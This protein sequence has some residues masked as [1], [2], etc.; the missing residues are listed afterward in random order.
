MWHGFFLVI[1]KVEQGVNMAASIWKGSISF[2]LINIPVILRKAEE[3]KSLS[4]NLLDERDL[5]PIKYKKVNAK[6]GH[7]VP[8]PKIVKGHKYSEEQYVVVTKED[9]KAANPKATQTIDIQ[10][11]ISFDEIDLMYFEKPY[12]LIPQ[13]SG[14]KGYYLLLE[15]LKKTNKVAVATVVI[16]SKMHLTCIMP[17]EN[18]LILEILRF[19]HEVLEIHEVDYFENLDKPKLNPKELKMAEELIEGMTAK[20]DPSLYKDTYVDDV[21]KIIDL[22]AKTGGLKEID[23]EN[24]PETIG[25]SSNVIDLVPLL[26]KSLEE[27]K[28]KKPASENNKKVNKSTK[29]IA[30]KQRKKA[31]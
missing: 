25:R 11:F 6:T 14:V 13:K 3:E 5:S 24:L 2:G 28:K 17:K 9:L 23:Y 29:K 16:R 15:A 22:K 1:N 12:Y 19:G 30:K 10:D 7:E 27:K 8:W 18:S 4:F 21:M 26:K 20:W 31:S